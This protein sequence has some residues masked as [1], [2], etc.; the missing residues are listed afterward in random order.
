[1]RTIGCV[2]DVPDVKLWS[3]LF[4]ANLATEKL[5]TGHFAVDLTNFPDENVELHQWNIDTPELEIM[6][7]RKEMTFEHE[8]LT[9]LA[10]YDGYSADEDKEDG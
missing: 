4:E 3:K 2:V 6:F 10:S 9:F 7:A 8:V 1:M 5:E